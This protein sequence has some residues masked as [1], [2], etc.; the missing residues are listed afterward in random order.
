MESITRSWQLQDAK[1]KF[2]ELVR[3]ATEDGP[4][5]V[6]KHGKVSVVVISVEDYYRLETPKSSL[7]DFFQSSPLCGAEFDIIRDESPSRDV[8]L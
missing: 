8:D 7:V 5:M 6:T 4:Q 1:N 2:S 3:S